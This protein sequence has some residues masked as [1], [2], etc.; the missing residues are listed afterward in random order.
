MITVIHGDEIYALTQ[1]KERI[2]QKDAKDGDLSDVV[3]IDASD[4]HMNLMQAIQE[5]DCMP[6]FHEKRLVIMNNPYFLKNAP[7]QVA[8]DAASKTAKKNN[9]NNTP[10]DPNV[11]LEN[12]LA[13]P[14]ETTDLVFFCSGYTANSNK[15]ETKLLKK[16]NAKFV[17]C[18]RLDEAGFQRRTDEALQREHLHLNKEARTELLERLGNRLDL[19]YR[20]IDKLFLYGEKNLNAEDIKN[21]IDE[22]PDLDIWKLGQVF[23]TGSISDI[24]NCTE[25]MI[26]HGYT[27]TGLLPMLASRLRTLYSFKKLKELGMNNDQIASYTKKTPGHV[28]HGLMDCDHISSRVL[29]C[30]LKNL[31]DLDQGIKQGIIDEREGYELMI[32]EK[33]RKHAVN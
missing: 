16:Y 24:L 28:Y 4:S 14:N 6:F 5:C 2:L 10:A 23:L 12:Y 27:Y 8:A 7:K 32:L 30:S 13:N 9:K 26:R 18:C 25:D 22:N 20:A 19:L 15:K 33:G 1:E 3:E 17:Q 11:I 29:L 31:A 21:L